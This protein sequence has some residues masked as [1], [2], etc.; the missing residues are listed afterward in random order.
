[1]EDKRYIDNAYP[2]FVDGGIDV[3]EKT[4]MASVDKNLTSTLMKLY[5][6]SPPACQYTEESTGD[7]AIDITMYTGTSGNLYI[8]WRLY[9]A[10]KARQDQANVKEHL[11]DAIEAFKINESLYA[12]YN[13]PEGKKRQSP[14]F[15]M[16]EPGL[17][18]LGAILYREKEDMKE[19]ERC[20]KKVIED[21]AMCSSKH[22]E[23][24][25]LYG[26]AGYLYCLLLLYKTDPVKFECKKFIV[27]IVNLLRKSGEKEIDGKHV[28]NYRFPRNKGHQYLGAAHGIFGIV[29]I[30]LKAT[31]AVEELA[32]D[33]N[34]MM[35]LENTCDLLVSL[36]TANGNFPVS[37]KSKKDHL[38]HFCH[39]A[40][41]LIPTL[42]A[43]HK[44]FR[45]EVYLVTALAA[46]EVV[47]TR[48]ILLKGNSLCHGITGNTYF[49][50][51]L[52]RYTTNPL[53][54]Y[55]F[56]CFLDATW[57]E[58]IQQS[59][60]KYSDPSRKVI[61]VPDSPYSLMEGMGGTIVL[62]ADVLSNKMFFPGYEL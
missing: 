35:L 32:K 5:K 30:L 15:F 59:T 45:K 31:E 8:Q 28:L 50:H 36:Q 18:T 22:A 26:N 10:Y 55:R 16:G 40:P 11:N 27:E 53:W 4:L 61:G 49:L 24:E 25:L 6:K 33:K 54:N 37:L 43:A 46:G 2:D 34:L 17:Y 21:S 14:S 56:S 13:K 19:C 7:Q 23:D 48:G 38:V 58:A 44:T 62:Y 39:G 57:N 1:M 47:W 51:T 41:G 52:Y 9:E 20:F 29:Y 42:L 60:Y 3:D 12:K